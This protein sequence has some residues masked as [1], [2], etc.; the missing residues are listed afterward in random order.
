MPSHLLDFMGSSSTSRGFFRND[1]GQP[2]HHGNSKAQS[3]S[4]GRHSPAADIIRHWDE[5]T[6]GCSMEPYVTPGTNLMSNT[7]H[8]WKF[9][10]LGSRATTEMAAPVDPGQRR[11]IHMFDEHGVR[12]FPV[13]SVMPAVQSL[14]GVYRTWCGQ[15]I[16]VEGSQPVSGLIINRVCEPLWRSCRSHVRS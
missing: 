9:H 10:G 11:T 6:E 14:S 2:S 8:S 16:S 12:D 1:L 3:S 5:G 13:V 7:A 4:P 15:P